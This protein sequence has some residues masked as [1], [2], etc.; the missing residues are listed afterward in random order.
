MRRRLLTL[1]SALS[2]LL[3][4]GTCV[5]WQRSD[6]VG[7]EISIAPSHDTLSLASEPNGFQACVVFGENKP[8][9]IDA[10]AVQW[11]GPDRPVYMWIPPSSRFLD[12][13]W[14]R[15]RFRPSLQ[16]WRLV[17]PYWFVAILSGIH[18][19]RSAR[20]IILARRTLPQTAKCVRCGYDLRATPER[21]PECGTLPATTTGK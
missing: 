13:R 2:L 15:D 9:R 7:Y 3:C 12:F 21:C 18:P 17:V 5:L 14:G 6:S 20:A 19:L 4:V 1:L 11:Y 10:R 16:Q 8:E